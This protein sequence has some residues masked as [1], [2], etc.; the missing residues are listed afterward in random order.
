MRFDADGLF[1]TDVQEKRGG[2]RTLGPMP[3]IPE[4]GWRPPT[5][6][7]NIRHAKWIS[8]DTETYDPELRTAGPGWARHRGHICGM[9]VAVEGA[10]WYFPMR[11]TIQPELNMDPGAVIKWASWALG[12]DG[13]KIGANLTYDVG[14]LAEEGV[15]VQGP[16]YDVQIAEALINEVSKLGL[17]ELGWKYLREGKVSDILKKWVL[18]YYGGSETVW[19]ENIYRS[20]V[21]L[22]GP[23]AE[24]DAEMPYRILTKQW[25]E[26]VSRGLMPLFEM[27]CG[28]IRL[29]VEM[30]FNGIQ[31]DMPYAEKLYEDL[32]VD[33]AR[34]QAEA[35][36]IAGMSVNVDSGGSLAKAFDGLGLAYPRTAP[37]EKHPNGQPSFTA[38]F[39]DTLQH[40]FAEKVREIRST[41]KVANT[42]VK[43]Y[44]LEKNIN[45]K[46]Y[47]SFKQTS[48]DKGGARTGRLAS[49]DPNLQNIPVRTE[50]G[51]KVRAAF[52]MDHGHLQ[53]RDFDYS[54]IEY[55]MLAHFATGAGAD[56]VR[57]KYRENPDLDYHD[58]IGDMIFSV[59]G[60]RLARSYVK[61]I[62]FGLV[63][64]LGIETLAWYLKT[65]VAHAKELSA[66]FHSAVPFAKTTM[67][68]LSEIVNQ[69][70]IVTTILNRQSHFDL[71][72]PARWQK[73]NGM[74]LP[75][76]AARA[77][78]G[79]D[80]IRAY[81]YRAIN[82][83]LQGS[84]AD[85]MK[86][87]MYQCY[88]Q[89]VFH[90]TGVPRL[91]V[92]DEL[93]FSD[94]GGKDAAFAEVKRI[95]ETCIPTTVPLRFDCDI[96]KNWAEAH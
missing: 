26:L 91:T 80:I 75:F 77:Q 69:T 6:L 55:R 73:R 43:S 70:G 68:D 85:C 24:G 10:K 35:N 60:I 52:I 59:T 13:V 57:E 65:T 18:Q 62:N 87:A 36:H 66:A 29:F 48:S 50:I 96:G 92:H 20:P 74:P 17:D 11:H 79:N 46:V 45:G 3:E 33:I 89:G 81:L 47:C 90:E 4:T 76:S 64:G 37:S 7:P 61:N 67:D 9:S 53:V 34:F 40:P 32:H 49:S 93:F 38:N 39:L 78:W 8:L 15:M 82:Y 56:E 42:F 95:C 51:K 94:P 12:G 58:M 23:Y 25:P 54:Q 22:A 31:I 88:K 21:T 30:R 16:L 2:P 5:E 19:R 83:R 28:L 63:Y 14:W 27:E 1:W 72:E 71:W 86:M 84:A 41:E 44:L